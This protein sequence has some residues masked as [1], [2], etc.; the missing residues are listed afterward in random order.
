MSDARELLVYRVFFR[1]L[2]DLF[3]L[4]EAI[5]IVA[6]G[7]RLPFFIKMLVATK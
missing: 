7:I 1:G 2:V 5:L 3:V 6:T 4:I